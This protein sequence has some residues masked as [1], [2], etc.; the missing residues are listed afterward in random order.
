MTLTARQKNKELVNMA[1]ETRH[2][3]AIGEISREEALE[4]IEPYIKAFNKKSKEIAKK[5]NFPAKTVSAK[6]FLRM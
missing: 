2:L 1:Y 3:Y 6:K 4:R 5:Y